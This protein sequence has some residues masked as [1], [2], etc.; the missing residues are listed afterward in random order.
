L[1]L[2]EYV[3]GA[4]DSCHVSNFYF[5]AVSLGPSFRTFTYPGF[6]D[7]TGTIIDATQ[8]GDN[9]T[10][11]VNVAT[12]G[13]YDIQLSYKKFSTRGIAQLSINGTNVG[14]T[15]DEYAATDSNAGFDFGAFNFVSAGNYSFQ[16]SV[17]GKNASSTGYSISF[18]DII[19]TPQ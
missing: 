10:F 11:T 5:A 8:V 14:S 15:L 6:P 7:T 18:D 17:M 1:N 12:A 3:H 9:V 13:I 4:E 16:F 19:L 2:L